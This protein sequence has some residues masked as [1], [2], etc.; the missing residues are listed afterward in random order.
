MVKTAKTG[1]YNDHVRAVGRRWS[2]PHQR[3]LSQNVAPSPSWQKSVMY[4]GSFNHC[5]S[6]ISNFESLTPF[7]MPLRGVCHCCCSTRLV[8]QLRAQKYGYRRGL[9]PFYGR[10][11]NFKRSIPLPECLPFVK[12][13]IDTPGGRQSSSPRLHNLVRCASVEV[14]SLL[15]HGSPLNGTL[16]PAAAIQCSWW[17]GHGPQLRSFFDWIHYTPASSLYETHFFLNWALLA[18]GGPYKDRKLFI[19]RFASCQNISKEFFEP[20]ATTTK[21]DSTTKLE[22]WWKPGAFSWGCWIYVF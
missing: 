1:G 13:R 21:K 12:R 4:R 7:E 8:T 20:K 22:N 2:W 17:L 16:P 10:W 15:S 19:F 18:C 14:I 9:S 3:V 11:C 5:S 6:M